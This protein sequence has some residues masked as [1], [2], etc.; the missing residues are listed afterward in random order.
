[1]WWYKC[2]NYVSISFSIIVVEGVVLDDVSELGAV[3][4]LKYHLDSIG[5]HFT[6][7]LLNH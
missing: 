4:V 2:N 6:L 1:M 7:A 3:I 5:K